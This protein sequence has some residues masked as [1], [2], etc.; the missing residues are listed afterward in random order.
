MVKVD[1]SSIYGRRRWRWNWRKFL[2]NLGVLLVMVATSLLVAYG[3]LWGFE[4][5]QR[6]QTEQT[7]WYLQELNK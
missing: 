7:Q 1:Y 6:I 3:L 5:E 2:R 4:R